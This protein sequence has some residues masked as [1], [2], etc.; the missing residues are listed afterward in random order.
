MI[1]LWTDDDDVNILIAGFDFCARVTE[2]E[3][4]RQ[5]LGTPGK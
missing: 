3:A 5:I 1:T 4:D 2:L